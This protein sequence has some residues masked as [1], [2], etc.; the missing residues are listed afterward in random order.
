MK[1]DTRN[2]GRSPEEV[3]A[4]KKRDQIL[5]PSLQKFGVRFYNIEEYEQMLQQHTIQGKEVSLY[6]SMWPEEQTLGK[7]CKDFIEH[8]SALG[9]GKVA[10]DFTRWP[11]SALQ[12][13]FH[14][15]MRALLD[16]DDDSSKI[17]SYISDFRKREPYIDYIGILPKAEDAPKTTDEA[18]MM[19]RA[20]RDISGK[21]EK[22]YHVAVIFD[23][24]AISAG[25]PYANRL[26][27]N[28]IWQTFSTPESHNGNLVL[29]AISL[30]D[31]NELNDK[32][33]ELAQS[34]GEWAHP[35][36]NT[37]GKVIFPE[38]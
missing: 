36:F 16:E 9:W 22:P 19:L 8:G 24:A 3:T 13:T 30:F 25:R 15:E 37:N 14:R 27:K 5:D 28:V 2:T 20:I 7:T 32:L 6:G 34:K 4:Q 35:L 11:Y 23:P 31:D 1:L 21:A 18:R 29:G 26:S 17:S 33:K 10:R 12:S 38:K